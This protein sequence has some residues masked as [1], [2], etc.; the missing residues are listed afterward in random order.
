MTDV[1]DTAVTLWVPRRAAEEP[2][3]PM[4]TSERL[5]AER[6]IRAEVRAERAEQALRWLYRDAYGWQQQIINGVLDAR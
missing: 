5:L 6:L 4:S 1:T 2:P 3:S